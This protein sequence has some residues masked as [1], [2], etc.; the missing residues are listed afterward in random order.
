MNRLLTKLSFAYSLFAF[1]ALQL[2]IAGMF[3]Q[4]AA[5]GV[6]SVQE[7]LVVSGLAV[8]VCIPVF[9]FAIARVLKDVE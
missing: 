9:A 1:F 2:L 8:A 6:L 3:Y 5:F 7:Q 4:W